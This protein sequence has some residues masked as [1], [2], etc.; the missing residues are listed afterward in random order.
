MSRSAAYGYDQRC[1][2]FGTKGL[3]SVD[4]VH[5]TSTVLS[6]ASGIHRSRLQHSFPQ[7]FHESFGAELDA[8]CDTLL[9]DKAWPV[10]AEQCIRVQRVADG[11]QQS[12]QLGQVVHL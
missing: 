10:T 6:N 8:F 5:E 9:L 11:A 12:S 1:E 4:N 7:R 3:I 2:I